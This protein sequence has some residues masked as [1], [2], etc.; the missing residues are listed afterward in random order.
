VVHPCILQITS[1]TG[2]SSYTVQEQAEGK[3]GRIGSIS[4]RDFWYARL[5]RSSRSNSRCI[6]LY[7]LAHSSQATEEKLNNTTFRVE[8]GRTGLKREGDTSDP[9]AIHEQNELGSS[10]ISMLTVH[11]WETQRGVSIPFH[12]LGKRRRWKSPLRDLAASHIRMTQSPTCATPFR[13]L[14]IRKL[15]SN[16]TG[17]SF[18]ANTTQDRSLVSGFTGQQLGTVGISLIHSCASI[19]G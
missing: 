3:S 11:I 15:A 13:S 19:I 7:T 16:S 1:A 17:S 14:H 6:W 4:L 2:F 8:P 18:P 5:Y 12:P 10:G 9:H